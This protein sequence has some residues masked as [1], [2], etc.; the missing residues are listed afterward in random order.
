MRGEKE[1]KREEVAGQWVFLEYRHQIS[2]LSPL[3]DPSGLKISEYLLEKSRVVG[4]SKGGQPGERT[5]IICKGLIPALSPKLIISFSLLHL[6][7]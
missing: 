5:N 1:R 7:F 6:C 4:Q 3:M 2:L